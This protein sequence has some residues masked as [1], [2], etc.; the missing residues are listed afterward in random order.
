LSV[1]ALPQTDGTDRQAMGI[2]VAVYF[3][4]GNIHFWARKQ[5]AS[6]SGV[7]FKKVDML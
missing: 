7:T 3:R 2:F 1:L 6:P 5:Q 4:S